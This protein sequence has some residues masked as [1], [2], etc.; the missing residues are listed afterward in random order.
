M[1]PVN[2]K[3]PKLLLR[4]LRLENPNGRA[5]WHI[6]DAQC[7]GSQRLQILKLGSLVYPA[8]PLSQG[9]KHTHSPW[10]GFLAAAELLARAPRISE[11]PYWEFL[12]V[13]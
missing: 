10:L 1:A 2:C 7:E 9:S 8:A 13:S 5:P 12:G 11:A 6:K 4:L 3:A